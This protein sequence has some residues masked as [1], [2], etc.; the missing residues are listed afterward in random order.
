MATI[1][2]SEQIKLYRSLFRGREDVFAVRWEKGK[3][4]GYMPAYRYD[5]YMYRLHKMKGGTFQTYPDKTY[6]NL[7]DKEIEKHIAGEQFMGIYPLLQDNTSWF[8]AADFD[9][10]NWVDE[11]QRLIYACV[12]VGISAYLERSQS[13]Q[14][15]HVW[16]FFEQP[17]PA[18]KSRKIFKSLLTRTG[19]SSI[20]EKDSSFDRLFPNQDMLS[21]KGLGNLIALPLHDPHL[22]QGNNCFINPET[23][24]PYPDQWV[25]LST[26]KRT[27]IKQLDQSISVLDK[28]AQ[29]DHVHENSVLRIQL[30]NTIRIN[31]SGLTPVLVNFL[32]E[33]LNFANSEFFIKKQSGKSTWG[34]ERYF[35]W[36]EETEH[37]IVLP[38]G[39]AGKL[40]RFCKQE[41]ID[42]TFLDRRI[43]KGSV[44]FN[45][46]LSLLSHQEKILAA[47]RK[48]EFGVIVAP[49]GAGKTV[50]A[51]KVISEKQQ[52]ALII[53]HRKQLLEQWVDRIESF[54]GIPRKKIGKIGQGRH[55]I[56]DQ[57][58]VA[59][60]Q[61]LTKKV[62]KGTEHSWTNAFGILV[63]DECHHIPAKNY[64]STLSRFNTYYQYGLTATPFRK[65]NDGKLIFAQL[66]E[67]IAEI[68]P[69]QIEAYKRARVIIKETGFNVPFN[70]KTDPFETLSKILIHDTARNK[71][72][73]K[74]VLGELEKGHKLVILTERRDHI[75]TLNQMLK[76]F[77]EVITISGADPE[78]AKKDKWKLLLAGQFQVI[79]TTGQF[80]GEGTDL[81][82]ISRLFL[83]Y[84]FS[85][86]GK[87]IQYIGRVQRAEIRPVIY[88]YR[89]QGV[90]YLNRLFL[91]RNTYY[92]H[93]D[94]QG[95]LF[96]DQEEPVSPKKVVQ[97]AEHILYPLK[98]LDFLY[99]AVAFTFTHPKINQN[100]EFEIEHDYIRPEFDVLKPYFSKQIGSTKIN[101]E[102]H[103]ELEDGQLVAQSASSSDLEKINREII[104]GMKFRFFEDT[105]IGGGISMES[106][107]TLLDIEQIQD[108]DSTGKLYKSG[109][110][111]L[112]TNLKNKESK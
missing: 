42:F 7:T 74:D 18:V 3:K 112:E 66:G 105:F 4:S 104:E 63:V 62:E 21:G 24:E 110:E 59:M 43:K 30:D 96:E 84:P 11:S 2:S 23:L 1:P 35:K 79:V 101:I 53:V 41:N 87:L 13:G 49:P 34:I 90:D 47:T 44:K 102:I 27:S 99:G 29:L 48:K 45:C 9:K 32:K 100:V 57:I 70:P 68:K 88:D 26:V 55:S 19:S 109:D 93:L 17:Y 107:S 31:R 89:D 75:N 67:I 38:R 14:G 33:E 5:P 16:I 10:D 50:I 91:K 15:G 111:L 39:F 78:S 58:T 8:I 71:L 103:V 25:F 28:S 22:Q 60:I 97:I 36:I 64:Y 40:L 85:F 65:Y 83:A 46:A 52:P 77:C 98:D 56:G 76:Q 81:H 61:T 86:K 51:L 108:D 20:F 95:N 73:L 106:K 12:E 80:F 69:E 92:R 94:K 72:I 82:N 37:E 6:R 54:L